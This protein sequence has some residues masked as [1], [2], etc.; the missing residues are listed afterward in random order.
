MG[1]Q[2]YKRDVGAGIVIGRIRSDPQ[3]VA[4]EIWQNGVWANSVT[5]AEVTGYG[6]YTDWVP[7]TESEA[8]EIMKAH[9]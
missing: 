8:K 9:Q 6:G 4:H 2:Y 3:T 5:L 7:I 1:T